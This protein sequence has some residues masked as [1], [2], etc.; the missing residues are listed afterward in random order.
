MKER[1]KQMCKE[2]GIALK[3]LADR[4]GI[5]RES[6]TRALD[7]N[8]TLSTLQGIANA[9]NVNVRDLFDVSKDNEFSCPNCGAKL[10][11]SAK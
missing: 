2:R 1:V 10:T 6:L 8:P 11:I 4:V 7:G 5:A 3:D 9:L